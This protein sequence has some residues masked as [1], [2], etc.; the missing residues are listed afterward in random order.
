VLSHWFT[1]KHAFGIST[2]VPI[3]KAK[4]AELALHLNLENFEGNVG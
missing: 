2:V 1:Q 4:A 3:I